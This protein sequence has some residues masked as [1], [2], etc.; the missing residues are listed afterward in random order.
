MA[1]GWEARRAEPWDARM[2]EGG[3]ALVRARRQATGFAR[4]GDGEEFE[5]MLCERSTDA[6]ALR[7]ASAVQGFVLSR[8]AV[9]QAELL[10]IVL[11]PAIRGGGHSHRLPGDPPTPL[12]SSGV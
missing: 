3:Q 2:M 8:R 5:R 6:H 10:T 12:N 1:E 11:A 9:D 4:P 7:R